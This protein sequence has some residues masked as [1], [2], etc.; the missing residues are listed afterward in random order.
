[1]MTQPEIRRD[2]VRMLRAAAA[3]THLLLDAAGRLPGFDRPAFV[4][5]ARGDRVMPPS[6]AAA[7]PASS[8]RA[9][10]P[11]STTAT[12]SSPWTSQPGSHR[13]S[14]SS[15]THRAQRRLSTHPADDRRQ[16]N[17]RAHARRSGR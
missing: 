4:V 8:R 12:P 3:D 17:G 2:A 16:R 6:M 7:S 9:S 10:W 13:S 15:P 14:V 1:V 11:R 5:W